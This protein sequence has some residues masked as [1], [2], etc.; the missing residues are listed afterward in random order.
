MINLRVFSNYSLG[1]SILKPEQIINLALLHKQKAVAMIDRMNMFGALEFSLYAI[2]KK[3]KPILGC[4]LKVKDYGYIPIYI[5][6]HQGYVGISKLLSTYYIEKQEYILIEQ[7][8]KIQDIIVI[9]GGEEAYFAHEKEAKTKISFLLEIFKDNFYVEIQNQNLYNKNIMLKYALELHIPVVYT[10]NTFFEK[11]QFEAYYTFNCIINSK[12]YEA[13]DLPN[14]LQ[15]DAF[16]LDNTEFIKQ[17]IYEEAIL[18]AES[19]SKRCNFTLEVQKPMIPEFVS[20]NSDQILEDL[21][22]EQLNIRL[23]KVI[24]TPHSVYYERINKELKILKEKGFCNYFLVTYDFIKKAKELNIPVGPGRGSGTGSLVAYS[25]GITNVNPIA[26]NLVFE[27]F[28][29]PERISLPDL[30]IDY[31]QEKRDLILE[32]LVEKYG[33]EN[34]AHILTFGTLKSRIVIRDVGR[35][36]RIPLKQIDSISKFIPQDQ[37]KPVTLKEAVNFDKKLME[38]FTL[39]SQ[40][41][42]L[43]NISLQL[44]G[45]I[46]HI[47]THAAGVVIYQQFNNN[48]QNTTIADHM[49][50]Y[51]AEN[52]VIC[53]QFSMKYVEMIGLVKFDFLG[54]QTLTL[55]RK[56]CELIQKTRNI[57]I[58][59]DDIPID[60]HLTLK[61]V[62]TLNLAG[63]FQLDSFGMKNIIYDLQPDSLEEI[64]AIIALFRPGPMNYIPQYISNKKGI[65]PIVYLVPILEP[66]LKNTYGILV[67][68]E[69]VLEIAVKVAKYSLGE[70]DNLRRSMGKKDPVEMKH[71]ESRFLQGAKENQIDIEVAIEIFKRMSD[72]AGYGFNKSHA[73]PYALISFQTAYL[74][75][76]YPLEFMSC[77]MTLDKQD[78]NKILTYY[79]DLKKLNIQLLSPCIQKSQLN[80]SIEGNNIRFGLSAIKNM[81][82]SFAQHI[83]T[84]RESNGSY[85]TLDDFIHRNLDHMNKRQLEY[86]IYSGAFDI[87]NIKKN[88]LIQNLPSLVKGETVVDN[89]L[90]IEEDIYWEMDSLGFF[91]TQHPMSK[92]D[93]QKL[94]LYTIEDV[95]LLEKLKSYI[96]MGGV[97]Y[98]I[99]KKKTHHNNK[100]YMFIKLLDCTGM[101]EVTIFSDILDKY[102]DLLHEKASLVLDV[103]YEK[104]HNIIKII[105]TKIMCFEAYKKE[106][107]SHIE[108]YCTKE[109][110]DV[111]KVLLSA[112]TKIGNKHKVILNYQKKQYLLPM[113]IDINKEILKQLEQSNISYK[114]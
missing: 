18:N 31:C 83:V 95:M 27:R 65:T 8:I 70:A 110:F 2:K 7:L 107:C 11:G 40:T 62:C 108:I 74:K 79:N 99:M 58:N 103:Q 64:I 24:N 30:D 4:L 86:L 87:L 43:L 104:K 44:E 76:H 88:L 67:Y 1:E 32:Y 80:F 75:T 26:F 102:I 6:N 113:F 91:L 34:I 106:I 45:L 78:T 41:E 84:E 71:Q 54:L 52:H 72:F 111:L 48:N 53:T 39:N 19:I 93:F 100:S 73:A 21:V 50:L 105:A 16:F 92:N 23:Q 63:V 55:I 28:L 37:V 33:K 90:I 68:Q 94:K 15:K 96:K 22:I 14:H 51:L 82:E 49:P 42:K 77:L 12:I 17:A 25:L 69:Q 66:I 13:D 36:L 114:Y 101:Y 85:K 59:I 20:E 89:N 10:H 3:I 61:F 9:W 57:I 29:N 81:G 35:T 60:D 98:N 47:S 109:K 112:F 38:M 5:K 56:T 46:R 97:V